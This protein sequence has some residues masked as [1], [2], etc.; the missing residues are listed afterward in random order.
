MSA[1]AP[2]SSRVTSNVEVDAHVLAACQ[3]FDYEFDG[4]SEFE[5]PQFNPP[6]SWGIGLIVGPSGS[7]KSQMLKKYFDHSG[8]DTLGWDGEK[9]VISQMPDDNQG[10]LMGVGLNSIPAWCRPFHVLSTGEKFRA[11][12]AR[13]VND[14]AVIDEFTS[15]VDRNVARACAN[16][17]CRYVKA[18]GFRKLVFATCHYDVEEWLQ[19]DWVFDTRTRE[20]HARD[21][22]RRPKIKIEIRRCDASVWGM[23]SHH[24]YLSETLNKS[25]RCFVA[26]WGEEVVGFAS[27]LAFPS[28]NF[29]NAWREHRTVVLPDYQGLGIGVRL[30]DAVAELFIEAGAR[31][32]SKTSHP[33]MGQYRETKG[34]W[35]P[36]SKN[37]KSRQDYAKNT[38]N[39]ERKHASAHINRVCFSHEYI[40]I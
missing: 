11:E 7:G 31:Y 34:L 37:R 23:F 26:T 28:G 35:R 16:A 40:G 30:S 20:L 1:P 4:T 29:K 17:V 22:L 3:S 2:V 8:E 6:E 19:P 5:I 18:R 33:R 36:T 25:S 10:R 39:K 32:F 13:R 14:G 24:H 12:M 27:A 21:C 9:A 38:G 15:T